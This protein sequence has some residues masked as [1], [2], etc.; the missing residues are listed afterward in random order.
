M[1]EPIR[2]DHG[3]FEAV[4]KQLPQWKVP[5]SVKQ[6]VQQFLDDLSLG[7]VN[8]GRK[9]PPERL[10]KYLYALRPPLEFFNKP[11]GRLALRD[12]ESLEK[13]LSSWKVGHQSTRKPY[14]P[15]PWWRSE[16]CFASSCVGGTES[17]PSAADES[18]AQRVAVFSRA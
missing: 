13:A 10:L 12:L 1:A 6:E 3:N 4:V 11:T 18:D 9:L 8:R 15:G 16:N 17:A 14:A 5:A 2:I 7:K